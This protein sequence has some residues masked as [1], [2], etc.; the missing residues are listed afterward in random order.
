MIEQMVK[1]QYIDGAEVPHIP[2]RKTPL[3]VAVYAPLDRCPVAPDVVV[4]RGD[5]RQTMLLAEAARTAGVADGGAAMGRPACAMLPAAIDTG[6]A[7]MSLGCIG[8]RVYTGLGDGELYWSIPGARLAA[9]AEKLAA[10]VGAN[11]ALAE[12]HA[13]RARA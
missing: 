3:A 5:A 1:L 10:I 2:T 11:R 9:I 12:M 6:R 13:A 7:H 8:N 4:V